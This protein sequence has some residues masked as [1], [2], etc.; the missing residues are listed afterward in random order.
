MSLI[1]KKNDDKTE[2]N[3]NETSTISSLFLDILTSKP[4]DKRKRDKGVIST[5]LTNIKYNIDNQRIIKVAFPVYGNPISYIDENNKKKGIM[6]DIW[7][8][9]WNIISNKDEY[10]N[11]KIQFFILENVNTEELLNDMI[12]KKYDIVLGDFTPTPERIKY[13]FFSNKLFTEKNVGVYIKDSTVLEYNVID[14][15][16][17]ILRYPIIFLIIASILIAFFNYFFKTKNS[18]FIDVYIQTINSFLGDKSGIISGKNY[19]IYAKNSIFIGLISLIVILILFLFLFYMQTI[20]ISRSLNVL[21]ENKD[22]FSFPKN[23]RVLVAYDS[24][25]KIE[26]KK[27]CDIDVIE[28]KNKDTSSDI[29]LLADEFL[30]RHE[31]DNIIGFYASSPIIEY[32]MRNEESTLYSSKLT[33][34]PTLFSEPSKVSFMISKYNPELLYDMNDAIHTLEWNGEMEKSCKSYLDRFCRQPMSISMFFK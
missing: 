10:K 34:S 30:E 11:A 6:I 20:V 26:L 14:K 17:D 23:K 12:N 13:T 16:A 1:K 22:P 19:N 24:P 31:K 28:S 2:S 8:K 9:I 7:N 18:S 4:S 3:K 29:K 27:C 33:I 32:V 15:L 25:Y 21:Q 5:S